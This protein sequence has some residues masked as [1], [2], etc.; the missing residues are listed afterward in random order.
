MTDPGKW[1]SIGTI[2][3]DASTVEYTFILKSFRSRVGDLIAVPMDAPNENYTGIRSII[4]WGR[5]TGI[6]RYNPFFPYEAAQELAQESIPLVDTVLST[7]RDQL[8]CKVLV[9]GFTSADMAQDIDLYPL[10]YPIPPAADVKYPPADAIRNL[11]AGGVRG[12]TPIGIGTLIAR[13]DV[14]VDMSAERVA[15][16]HLAILA[17]TGGGKTVA[18]RR[19]IRDLIDIGYPVVIFDPHG[20]YLGLWEKRKV[21]V[22]SEIKLFF[23]HIVMTEGN[24]RIVETLIAKMTEGLTEPQKDLMGWLLSSVEAKVGQ[25]VLDYINV[26]V[27][28]VGNVAAKREKPTVARGSVKEESSGER[29][30]GPDARAFGGATA[31]AVGRSLRLVRDQ[32]QRMET[33]NTRMRAILKGLDFEPL[34]DPEGMPEAIVAPRQVSILYLGGYDHLT[35]STIVSVLMEAL[36]GHRA[37]LADRIAPFLTVVEEA[38]NFVPSMREGIEDT[39]SLATLRRVITEGRKFGV[40]LVL[41]TQRPSRVDETILAQCNS[42]LVMRLVN[43]RDQTYVRSVM[44]NLSESDA[45]MLPGFGPGQGIVSGQAVR[46][47]LLVKIKFDEDLIGTR[48]GDE[49]FIKRALEW[50]PD[51]G[52]GAR[53][54]AADAAKKLADRPSRPGRR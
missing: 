10:T 17:M 12:Q 48:T 23:P 6:E 8:Q 14:A 38:H 19:I 1:Q 4:A 2:V 21:F 7:S 41:V 32:L 36:F 46:F 27:T 20:D 28:V 29:G 53:A 52:A 39:P 44:E 13:G 42:F 26:L 18:V 49:N 30:E 22:K 43:P 9:L 24:R 40:G 54:R 37:Q 5:I 15:S 33:S 35:Q 47:P 31:R 16:R 25:P 3:G 50:K 34:P 51:R 45:R 11:L